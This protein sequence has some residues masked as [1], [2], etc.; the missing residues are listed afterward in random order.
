MI[1]EKKKAA[2]EAQKRSMV[3]QRKN[4][5]GFKLGDVMSFVNSSECI[6]DF[7]GNERDWQELG[8]FSN[9]RIDDLFFELLQK[10]HLEIEK[11]KLKK[12]AELLNKIIFINQE[13]DIFS[14]KEYLQQAMKKF[15]NFEQSSDSDSDSGSAIDKDQ[16]NIMTPEKIR[17]SLL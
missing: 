10:D 7:L 12:D 6:W 9:N 14:N 17:K 1:E 8:A 11:L 3:L 4:D 2:H 15:E 13:G 5:I 16:E